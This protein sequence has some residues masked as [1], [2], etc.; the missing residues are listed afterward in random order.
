MRQKTTDLRAT[1]WSSPSSSGYQNWLRVPAFFI[2]F[3]L[4]Y[5]VLYHNSYIAQLPGNETLDNWDAGWYQAIKT[6]GIIYTEGTACTAGFF[7][8]L[9]YIWAFLG[10]SA[11]GMSIFNLL[12]SLAGIYIL[13]GVF[14]PAFRDLLLV[15]AMPSMFFL[16]V[17][18]TEA[19]F[20]LFSAL[21][22]RGISRD[23]DLLVA[24]GC[25]LASLTRPTMLFLIP[26]FIFLE[27]VSIKNE[28]ETAREKLRRLGLFYVLPCLLGVF[29]IVLL[30]YAETGEWFAYFK[31]QSDEW[32]RKFRFPRFPMG[33]REG[34]DVLWL[35]SIALWFGLLALVVSAGYF[36]HRMVKKQKRPAGERAQLFSIAYVALALGSI[37]FFNPIWTIKVTITNG[38]NRYIFASAFFMCF[39]WFLLKTELP[40]Y[41]NL[42][43]VMLF[44]MVIWLLI[45]GFSFSFFHGLS[46]TVYIV[47]FYW[48]KTTRSEWAWWPLFIANT[49]MQAYFFGHFLDNL[50]VG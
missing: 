12:V 39:Y 32:D 7:P 38:M 49:G 43:S 26:A 23:R 20:L 2:L 31:I 42:L 44:T 45:G 41:V 46:L 35:D 37:L 13:Y 18:Y 16:Y 21:I 10:L 19:L 33:S 14:R 29:M 47:V 24:S 30:Q 50:W 36:I 48:Y 11:V 8:T 4:A 34:T 6:K 15:L 5:A 9:S 17:P 25:F 27:L 1:G 22:L 28:G 40:K 3:G